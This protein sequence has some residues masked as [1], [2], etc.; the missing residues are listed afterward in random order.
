MI[1][2]IALY[3]KLQINDNYIALYITIFCLNSLIQ[4]YEIYP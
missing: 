1:L 2:H 3:I 4:H